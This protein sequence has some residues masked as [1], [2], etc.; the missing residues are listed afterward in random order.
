MKIWSDMHLREFKFW[1]G[2]KDTVDD[3]Y[4]E[5]LDALE[6]IIEEMY[7]EGMSDYELNQI[8]WFDRDWIAEKLGYE[9][10]EELMW[11]K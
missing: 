1:S 4:E 10:Y 6:E 11:R 8:F 2:G 5:E 3:L 9:K 7:P